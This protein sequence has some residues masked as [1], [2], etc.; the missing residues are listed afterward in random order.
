MWICDFIQTSD[1][2]FRQVYDL[3]IEWFRQ[4]D[5]RGSARQRR[6]AC[7]LD[8]RMGGDQVQRT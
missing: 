6:F 3:A 8:A 4:T 7:A 2:L 5:A 1:L